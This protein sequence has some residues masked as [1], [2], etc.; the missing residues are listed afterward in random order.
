MMTLL[1]DASRVQLVVRDGVTGM[2]KMIAGFALK[3]L[4][5]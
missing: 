2:S 5:P 4:S 1:S 3:G